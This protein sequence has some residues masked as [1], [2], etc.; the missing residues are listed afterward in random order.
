MQPQRQHIWIKCVIKLIQC[1]AS[2]VWQGFFCFSRLSNITMTAQTSLRCPADAGLCISRCADTP[3]IAQNR[4]M[5]PAWLALHSGHLLPPHTSAER[6]EWA[7]SDRQ[8][9]EGKGLGFSF[10]SN[11]LQWER[12]PCCLP[13]ALG[14]RTQS[15]EM[16]NNTFNRKRK[17]KH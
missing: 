4:Q 17:K 16:S 2:E 5:A 6:C 7:L 1:S 12:P 3:V 13:M 9:H 10:S 11:F 14:K 15:L 8:L